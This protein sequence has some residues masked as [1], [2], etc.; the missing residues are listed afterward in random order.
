MEK[1]VFRIEKMDCASEENMVRMKLQGMTG[2]ADLQFD[3]PG[4]T[5]IVHHDNQLPAIQA[6]L[7]GLRLGAKL[8][9]NQ[10]AGDFVQGPGRGR[11]EK[12]ALIA[13]FTINLVLFLGELTA[14]LLAGSMGLIADSL[15]N[16]ADTTVYGLSLAA[17]GRSAARKN[18]AA[19]MSGYF[20]ALLALFGLVEVVRR[21]IWNESLPEFRTMIAVSCLTMAGNVTTLLLLTKSGNKEAHVK[22]SMIFTSN[23]ILVNLL[24]V[25]SG[26]LVFFTSSRLPDLAAGGFIFLIVV[27]G[28]RRI[29]ALSK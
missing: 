6:S 2:V 10:D 5:L 13:A 1:A 29:L 8:T 3:L 24:V 11:S 12:P 22:A 7:E 9:G 4:R 16:L 25:L 14:G 27:N 20:Q 26:V 19:R 18:G 17:V 21:F 28:A 23:D 15:D